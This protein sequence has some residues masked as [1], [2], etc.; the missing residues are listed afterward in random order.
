MS[1]FGSKTCSDKTTQIVTSGDAASGKRRERLLATMRTYVDTQSSSRVLKS[2]DTMTGG[3]NMN[4]NNIEGL[5]TQPL[6]L[7]RGDEALS[8]SRVIHLIRDAFRGL[9]FAINEKRP[10]VAVWAEENGPLSAGQYEFSFGNGATG[11]LLG[12]PMLVPGKII[13]MGLATNPLDKSCAVGLVIDGHEVD[14][15]RLAKSSTQGCAIMRPGDG[16]EVAPGNIISFM[17]I[18]A[19][20]GIENATVSLLIELDL[21]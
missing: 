15:V 9:E 3:L 6:A 1:I 5:P 11:S 8:A 17:T 7:Y 21:A 14:S 19:D 13:R 10:V 4:G 18:R 20:P 2:G 16:Y 12:Y